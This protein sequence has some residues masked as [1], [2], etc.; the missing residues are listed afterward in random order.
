MSLFKNRV[1][2]QPSPVKAPVSTNPRLAPWRATFALVCLLLLGAGI[3]FG[4]EHA[5]R[6][7][8]VDVLDLLPKDEQDA[9]IRLAR[10][11]ANGRLGRAFL[12]ALSDGQN[13]TK[14][15]TQAAAALS[16]LLAKDSAFAGSFSGFDKTAKEQ[17]E[18]WFLERRLAIRLP[19]WLDQNTQL[20]RQE[21]PALNEAT[22]PVHW[23]CKE[24]ATHLNQFQSTSEATIAQDLLPRD[25]LLLV[26]D[27]LLSF[28]SNEKTSKGFSEGPLTAVGKD[29]IHYALIY[30]EIKNSPLEKAGQ[31]PVFAAVQTAFESIANSMPAHKLQMKYTGVNRIASYTR[32]RAENEI[33]ILTTISLALSCLL[34]LIVF[35][36][37]AVF[38]YLL[39]PIITATIW[40][41]VICF[42]FFDQLHAV[43]IIFTTVLVG[44]ALDYGIYTLIH[45]MRTRDAEGNIISLR[46]SLQDIRKPLITGCLVGVVGFIFMLTTNLPMLQQMGLAVALGLLFALALDFLYLPWVPSTHPRNLQSAKVK[47]HLDLDG[48][49][50]PVVALGLVIAT[51]LWLWW[52]KPQWNDNIQSLQTVNK[53]LDA[54]DQMVR[55][56]FGQAKGERLILVTFGDNLNQAFTNVARLNQ[57]L[58]EVGKDHSLKAYF[59]LGR[60]FPDEAQIGK[61]RHYFISHPEF[62]STLRQALD[63][64]F[65]TNAFDPFWKDFDQWLKEIQIQTPPTPANWIHS[66]A[67]MVPLPLKNL[68]SDDDHAEYAW[69]ATQI[70]Q[71]LYHSVPK[72]ALRDSHSTLIDQVET[73]NKA[74]TRYRI[75]A[76]QRA[77]IG[78]VVIAIF[79]VCIFGWR[80]GLFML[81]IP[82]LSL[83]LTVGVLSLLGHQLGL[84]HVVALLLGYC[85]ASDY[86]IYLGSPGILHHST[87]YAIRLA[88]LTALISFSVLSFSTLP[89][90]RF[91]C[92]TDAIVLAF[93]IFFCELAYALFAKNKDDA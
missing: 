11:T 64:D 24:A 45:A 14:P 66:F 36:K 16:Q 19:I 83:L 31:E 48:T 5:H 3:L 92:L 20:W 63:E 51:L 37:I 52:L 60:I 86:S 32:E 70:S 39:L 35:R 56:M 30:A 73:L 26:P 90:L 93:V 89:A 1:K 74:L 40:S 44:I 22:P 91:I 13:P 77:G 88:A 28:A 72:E 84:L 71:D 18:K 25:P 15:P 38:I 62:A 42:L 68:W 29:Q 23:L 75:A 57:T 82:I 6:R 80:R 2:S 79:I 10:Q 55:S 12:I 8:S 85:L 9:T 78:A 54:E 27:L 34:M 46:R 67:D 4:I 76:M 81:V 47:Q 33:R 50:F 21:N 69:L 41:L 58:A 53:T 61:C 7:I 17:L 87:R 65:N 59:N 43:T 49:L